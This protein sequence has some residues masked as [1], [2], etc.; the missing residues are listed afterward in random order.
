MLSW[1]PAPGG[2]FRNVRARLWLAAAVAFAGGAAQAQQTLVVG[3][4][5]ELS[6]QGVVAENVAGARLWFDYENSQPGQ[7]FTIVLK[8]YDDK[9][10]PKSTVAYT[11]RLVDED[12]AIAL[13]GYHSTPS[14][15]ALS[16]DFDSLGI[17][18]VAPFNGSATLRSMARNAFF[19]RASYL[20]EARR[21]VDQVVST[22]GGNVAIVHQSDAFGKEGRDDYLQAL[23]AH[24]VKPAAV[25]SYDRQTMNTDGVVAELRRL[26]PAAALMAC[27]PK[28]CA[29]I[30]NRVRKENS[31]M[32]I[33]LLSNAVNND[34]VKAVAAHGRSVIL[35]QVVPYP[36][37]D[38][39][40]I[41]REFNR[42]N[43]AAPVRAPVSYAS[44][45]GFAAAK[46]LSRAI[47]LAGPRPTRASLLGALRS[48]HGFDLGGI[49]FNPAGQHYYTEVTTIGPD[50][51]IIR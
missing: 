42:L 39:T 47:H 50:G 1:Q 23:S 3:Q 13:F 41:V 33:G 22:G 7:A 8:Q 4:V 45:E 37:N 34:F 11:R 40:P 2:I 36:W 17:A 10:D 31:S 32:V 18:L 43:A 14:L 44:L 30:I 51:R 35:S 21:L 25:L 20:D 19:L 48:M 24:G 6:G 29:D 15:D 16:K 12:N 28:A 49:V 46:L 27:T 9:R 5:A 38:G 26:R